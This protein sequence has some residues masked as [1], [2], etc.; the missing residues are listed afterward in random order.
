L[1]PYEQNITNEDVHEMLFNNN[2]NYAV[3][4]TYTLGAPSSFGGFGNGST[5]IL[6]EEG[7]MVTT[8]SV[9]VALG[10][11]D[12]SDA[13]LWPNFGG[14]YESDLS[15]LVGQPSYDAAAL[16]FDITTSEDYLELEYVFASEEYCDWVG[17][18]FDDVFGVF[19]SGPGINGS[20]ENNAVL[21]SS[22]QNTNLPVSINN[23]N[24]TFFQN[25]YISNVPPWQQQFS[26]GCTGDELNDP[27]AAPDGIEFDGFTVPMLAG[28]NIIPGETYHVK[29]AIADMSDPL[30]DSGVFLHHSQL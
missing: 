27:P 7:L 12:E 10:P 26:G 14:H 6:M 16:H 5:S 22:P 2:S 15:N 8:G 4:G 20:F 25:L 3:S 28:I 9:M 24:Y 1:I 29:V 13:T 19:V 30:Y 21:V 11:N 17:S 23:I 18:Q